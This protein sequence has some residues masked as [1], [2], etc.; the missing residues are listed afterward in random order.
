MLL[1]FW[2]IGVIIACIPIG[3]I[4]TIICVDMDIRASKA[5][6]IGYLIPLTVFTAYAV[7]FFST[8]R[9]EL[10][11]RYITKSSG[12]LW[13]KRR[14]TPL[15][16][17][18]N[19]DVRQGPF[20]RMLGYGQIWIF[21]PSTG[22]LTPEAKLVGVVNPHEIKGTIVERTEVA[23]QPQSAQ[24]A[25]VQQSGEVVALLQEIRN[26]LKNIELS[27]T[28]ERNTGLTSDS[29]LRR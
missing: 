18:T 12:V 2:I 4:I 9:Y 15:E 6:G 8:I 27:L 7:L 1:M 11:Q 26:S 19:I 24:S 25:P 14:M 17:I 22:A 16:K 13:K 29:T 21:T 10:D 3:G 23:R 28:T 20:E 5:F